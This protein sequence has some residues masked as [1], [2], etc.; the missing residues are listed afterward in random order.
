MEKIPL[1]DNSIDC[2]ISNG[3][4]C[5]APNK[6]KSFEEIRRVLK[7]GGRFSVAC[8][9]TLQNLDESVKWPICMQ[10]FMPLQDAEPLLTDLGFSDVEIDTSDSK[11]TMEIEIPDELLHTQSESNISISSSHSDNTK[12][13]EQYASGNKNYSSSQRKQIHVGSS[14]FEHLKDFN[15]NELC[16]RVILYGR[17]P[18]S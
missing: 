16:A 8:T 10:V 4:F 9:T 14:E 11:M 3:A 1:S 17:K 5:L 7:P 15:V 18:Y 13:P 12:V 2:V 6:R